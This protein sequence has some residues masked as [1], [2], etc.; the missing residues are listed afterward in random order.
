[1][2]SILGAT[3]LPSGNGFVFPVSVY[4]AK[5]FNAALAIANPNESEAVV[6]FE[7]S[8]A[9][10]LQKLIRVIQISPRSQNTLSFTDPSLF[11]LDAGT[12]D[13]FDGSVTVCSNV[14]IG[15]V[16]IGLAGKMAFTLPVTS[17]DRCQSSQ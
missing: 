12:P 13:R 11:N 1:V 6:S 17:T 5:D 16:P 15:L 4:G 8:Y 3:V 2:T 7:L 9:D 14:P 10:G